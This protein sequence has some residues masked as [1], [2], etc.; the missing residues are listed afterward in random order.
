MTISLDAELA[1]LVRSAAEAAQGNV[2]SWLADAARR[3]LESQGLLVVINDWEA[4][5][6]AISDQEQ[7]EARRRLGWDG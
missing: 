1:T 6:G 5:H 3:R 7:G 2:S 4:E